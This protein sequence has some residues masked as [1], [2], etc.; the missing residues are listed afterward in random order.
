LIDYR[1]RKEKIVAVKKKAPVKKKATAKK[2]A[3]KK[4][5]KKA[6]AKKA[7]AKKSAPKKVAKKATAKKAVAKKAVAKKAT[8][9]KATAKKVAKKAPAKKAAASSIVIPPVP[10]G[11]TRPA[12]NV[13]STPVAPTPVKPAATTKPSAAPRQGSSKGVLIAVLLGVVVLAAI[14]VAGQSKD[15]D[16]APAAPAPSVSASPSESSAPVT[17][18][19][20]ESSEAAM[21]TGDAPTNAKGVWKDTA[22]SAI[23]LTW[24]APTGDVTGYKV[25]ISYGKTWNEIASLPA[26]SLSQDIT[27]VSD[28]G[29]TSVRISAIY[30]DGSIGTADA[31][32][33]KGEFK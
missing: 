28:N 11:S 27:K 13:A 29:G 32:G 9:K 2:A 26:T 15:S 23:V 1:Y 17:E 3:P 24:N 16:D 10:N 33:F 31:F 6:V 30:S 25:E 12:V 22:K 4:V 18:P 5:A 21:A 14:V 19:T 20:P 7:V 8:A